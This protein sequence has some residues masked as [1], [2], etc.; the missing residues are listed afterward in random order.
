MSIIK[1]LIV[2]R[3]D[4]I[5]RSLIQRLFGDTPDTTPDSSYSAPGNDWSSGVAFGGSNKMEPPKDV[6]P[7]DGYEVVL[8]KDALVSGEVTEVI[9]AG[10]AIAMANVEGKFY[11]V[12]SS[13]PNA[14]GP[15]SEGVLNGLN[16]AC[17]Y[18]GW[19]FSL[20][21]GIGGTNPDSKIDV[22]DTCVTGDAVCVSL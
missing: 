12:S 11:A 19:S 15:L 17:P 10:K 7:P 6:T 4:G 14:E 8:H 20:E 3:S 16:L 9:I 21:T 18:C 22:Y 13:C 5:R 2:G 1:T